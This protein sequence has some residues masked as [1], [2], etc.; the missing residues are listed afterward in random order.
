MSRNYEHLRAFALEHAWAV[1]PAMLEIVAAVLA[2]RV[3]GRHATDPGLKAALTNRRR[4]AQPGAGGAV[5]VIPVYGLIVPRASVFADV[6]GLI[7]Y[8]ALTAQVREAVKT[9]SV[10]SIVLDV[11][12]PGG[13]VA[14]ATEFAQELLRA[15][16][17]KPITA[18]AHYSMCSS[19]YW[20][21]ACATEVV[22]APSAKVGSIGVFAIHD[23]LSKALEQE[24]ISRTY[25]TAGKYKA[26]DNESKPLNADALARW[27]RA[28]NEATA[29]FHADVSR[30]RGVPLQ[31]VRTSFGQGATL[32]AAD[33]LKAGMVDRIATL[34]ETVRRL[35]QREQAARVPDGLWRATAAY[36]LTELIH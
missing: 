20:L 30:G 1:T 17:K 21:G 2:S 23:D 15:R 3:T 33:A 8:E 16:K 27:Q 19:A 6:S 4:L 7:S 14:G 10:T 13:S 25:I 12:S 28:V 29:T 18:V 34:D 11:D 31:R 35:A 5:A 32:S 36:A 22:A 9:D 26:D 24:G